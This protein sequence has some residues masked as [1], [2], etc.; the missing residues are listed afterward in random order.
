[1]TDREISEMKRA[2]VIAIKATQT[3]AAY[4]HE[5]ALEN[6]ASAIVAALMITD[7]LRKDR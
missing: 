2:I 1:M 6:I 5:D 4:F 7:A 3:D